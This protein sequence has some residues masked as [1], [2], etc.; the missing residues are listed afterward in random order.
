MI[1]IRILYR[2]REDIVQ[3]RMFTASD[4]VGPWIE[5]GELV[6][7]LEEWDDVFALLCRGATILQEE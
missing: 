7:E 6:F 1:C 2:K 4:P 3:C 5:K